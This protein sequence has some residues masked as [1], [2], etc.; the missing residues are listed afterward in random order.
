MCVFSPGW[1]VPFWKTSGRKTNYLITTALPL[2]PLIEIEGNLTRSKIS[3]SSTKFV[4]FGPIR[5]QKWLPWLIPQ[6]GGTLYSGARYVALWASCLAN[7]PENFS[8]IFEATGSHVW[9]MLFLHYF[10]QIVGM[11]MTDKILQFFSQWFSSK[12]LQFF[13]GNRFTC[14][15]QGGAKI[16]QWGVPSPK[17]CFFR[18]EDYSDKTNA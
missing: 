8:R 1:R 16:G 15:I 4:F 18:L 10:I 6:K 7:S 12:I 5:R 2:K 9:D 13:G 14:M 17:D 11:S 3:M